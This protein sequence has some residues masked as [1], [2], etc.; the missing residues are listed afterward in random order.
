MSPQKKSTRRISLGGRMISYECTRK[1]IKNINIHVR[2]D[3]TVSVSVP[4]TVPFSYMEELLV[5]KQSFILRSVDAA[6]ERMRGR[7]ADF[8]CGDGER[9]TLLGREYVLRIT[10]RGVSRA[11]GGTLFLSLKRTEDAQKRKEALKR[12]AE[13][14]LRAYAESVF[15]ATYPRFSHASP[16]PTLKLRVMRARWGS[17]RPKTA[18]ITLNTRLALYPRDQI[19]YV[20]AHE[21]THL[22]HADH[23]KAFYTALAALMPDWEQRRK[24]LNAL[25]M[26]N[27]F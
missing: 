11:E 26:K 8:S 6:R 19:D 25:P 27:H 10:E 9:V 3:G 7:G 24:E 13:K 18:V 4:Y 22:L 1:R 12:F 21:F 17:C 20:I 2:S 15:E 5:R 23:S 14:E 16:M